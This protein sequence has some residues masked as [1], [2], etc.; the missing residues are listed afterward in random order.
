MSKKLLVIGAHSADFV[1]RSAGT[2]ALVTAQGGSATV[3][4]LSYG[5]RGESGELW[6][7]AGQTVEN[8]K[9]VRHQEAESAAEAVGARFHCMD[10]GDY[11]LNITV[12]AMDQ[13]VEQIRDV[14]PDIILTHTPIDPFN[15]DHPVAYQAVQRARLLASGAGVASAFQRINPP[16]LYLFEPHQPELCEFTPNTFIDITP[17]MDKKVRAM[18]AM[19]AQSYLQSYYTELASRR[20]NHARRISGMSEIKYAEAL[21]RTLPWVVK[22]L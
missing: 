21:Q 3:I 10:L 1:W 8:V 9:R 14:Q 12:A 18:E 15:P 5:E 16:D 17:V 7:E 19:Q 4:A 11:P 13:L 20:G 6:K 22:S 2:I